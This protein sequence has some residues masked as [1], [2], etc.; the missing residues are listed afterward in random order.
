MMTM[1]DTFGDWYE[2]TVRWKRKDRNN[3]HSW[4]LILQAANT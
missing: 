1:T 3:L 4:C 2:L